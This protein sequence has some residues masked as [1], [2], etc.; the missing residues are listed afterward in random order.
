MTPAHVRLGVS[1]LDA[2]ARF[3]GQALGLN[4]H[5]SGTQLRISFGDFSLLLEE[6]RPTERAKIALGFRV[7]SAALL[8]A[9]AERA[10]KNGGH[11]LAGPA[12]GDDGGQTLLLM[13]PD[14]YQLEIVAP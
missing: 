11:V 5:R 10:G 1:D 3:Y 8:G 6:A 9:I 2:S 14:Q 12:A 4:V 7:P 13:D